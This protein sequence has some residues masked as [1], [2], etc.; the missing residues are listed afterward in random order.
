MSRIFYGYLLSTFDL[1]S[2]LSLIFLSLIF[3][4]YDQYRDDYGV[5]KTATAIQ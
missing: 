2:S 4:I 3:D 1:G 5:L